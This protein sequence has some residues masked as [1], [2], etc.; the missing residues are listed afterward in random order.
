MNLREEFESE[1]DAKCSGLTVLF[2]KSNNNYITW[3]ENKINDAKIINTVLPKGFLIYECT[4]CH[5]INIKRNNGYIS[6]GFC[7]EC[8]HVLWNDDSIGLGE[9]AQISLPTLI[10]LGVQVE[11][12]DN[13]EIFNNDNDINNG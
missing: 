3:L 6:V 9:P 8:E 7:D 5:A 12:V 1:I 4:N 13:N 10:N 2:E 11:S